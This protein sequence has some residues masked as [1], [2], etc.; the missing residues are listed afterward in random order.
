MKQTQDD[1]FTIDCYRASDEADLLAL[2]Q[3]CG[4]VVPWNNPYADIARKLADSPG[5]FF[6]GKLG[7]R[8]VA[9]CM[10]GYDGHRGWIYYLAVQPSLQRSGYAARLVAHSE[11]KL[12]A[13]GCPKI[14]LMVRN[15][16]QSVIAFYQAIGYDLD[17]VVVLSKRLQQDEAQDLA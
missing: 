5:L 3:A 15:S 4:L 17:P 11:R 2:W 7:D 16:N 6:V 8:L 9:S 1:A 10:A 12:R 14:D 13:L